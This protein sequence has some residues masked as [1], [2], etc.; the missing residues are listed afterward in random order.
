MHLF[1]CANKYLCQTETDQFSS[2]TSA[3]RKSRNL[4]CIYMLYLCFLCANR[5]FVYIQIK[6]AWADLLFEVGFF[7]G[8]QYRIMFRS[9]ALVLPH[10]RFPKHLHLFLLKILK[11]FYAQKKRE[12][13]EQ[14]QENK[15]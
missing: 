8:P 2:Q 6:G 15:I 7:V 1:S 11:E 10:K 12:T 5:F 4:Y 13:S 9:H 3:Q 14:L